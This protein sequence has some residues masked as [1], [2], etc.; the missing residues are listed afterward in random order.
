MEFPTLTEAKFLK[1]K[2]IWEDN[3][4]STPFFFCLHPSKLEDSMYG[5]TKEFIFEEGWSGHFNLKW[6]IEEAL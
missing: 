1:H 5:K 2:N 3:K 6:V 4:R